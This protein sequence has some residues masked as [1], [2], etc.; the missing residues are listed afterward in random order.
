MS[1]DSQQEEFFVPVTPNHLLLGHSGEDAPPLDYEDNSPVTARMAYVTQ[2]FE[3]WWRLWVK[4]VLPTLIP[5]RKWKKISRNIAVGDVC[6][7]HYLGNF[8]DDYRMVKVVKTHPDKK[9]CVRT[10][11]VA[12]RKKDKR[13]PADVYWKKPLVEEKVAVQRLSI[14][15]SAKE[16]PQ[17][18][19]AD[20][21]AKVD[22][23]DV[24]LFWSGAGRLNL[25]NRSI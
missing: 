3:A 23:V 11:T 4:Q 5:A 9:N 2:V 8:K 18:K 24:N 10:V 19:A 7:M 13:E 22:S 12:F 6:F 25:R 15:V 20:E 16:Q 14:L 21:Q 17:V 1:G